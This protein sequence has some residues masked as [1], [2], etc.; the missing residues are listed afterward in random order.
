VTLRIYDV[1]G[2]VVRTL[3]DGPQTAGSRAAVWDGRS[4]AGLTLAS[5]VYLAEVKAGE[6][7]KRGRLVLLK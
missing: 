4:D 3:V 1:A 5:G 7:V 2:R 6:E